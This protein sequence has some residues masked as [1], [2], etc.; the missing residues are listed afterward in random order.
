MP[1][2]KQVIDTIA[3]LLFGIGL[4]IFSK[5]LDSTASNA[6]PFIFEYLDLRNFLSRFAIWLFLALCISIYSRSSIRASLN[7]FVFLWEWFQ[8]IICTQNS[9]QAFSRKAMR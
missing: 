5:F 1:V 3:L 7:V 9:R 4:G 8:A 6:L 2:R